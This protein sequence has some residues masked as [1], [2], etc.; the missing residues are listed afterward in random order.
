MGFLASAATALFPPARAVRVQF[1]E[2]LPWAAP[3][4]PTSLVSVKQKTSPVITVHVT[5]L[6]EYRLPPISLASAAF[7]AAAWSSS[8]DLFVFLVDYGIAKARTRRARR[9]R[10]PAT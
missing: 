5:P 8:Q 9:A 10:R 3:L 4:V 7:A 2:A 6:I 1:V